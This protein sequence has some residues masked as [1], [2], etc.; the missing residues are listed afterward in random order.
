MCI[1]LL[2]LVC[3]FFM[4]FSYDLFFLL[5][6]VFWTMT[7]VSLLIFSTVLTNNHRVILITRIG[8]MF[9]FFVFCL[10]TLVISSPTVD[11]ALLNYQYVSELLTFFTKLFFL[12]LLA[13]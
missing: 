2:S 13:I 5:P 12:F 3:I 1:F 8:Y 6:E 9:I 10:L 7:G 4:L 11:Y